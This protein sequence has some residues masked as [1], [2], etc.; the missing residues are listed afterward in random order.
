MTMEWV[1]GIV[2]SLFIGLLVYGGLG[3]IRDEPPKTPTP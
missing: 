3:A 1:V 2:F